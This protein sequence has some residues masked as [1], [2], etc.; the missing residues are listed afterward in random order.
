[1][2]KIVTPVSRKPERGL[3][4]QRRAGRARWRELRDGGRELGRIGD[5]GHAPDDTDD[6][7]DERRGAERQPDGIALVPEMAM[8]TI[9]TAVRPSRS[10]TRPATMHPAPPTPT[11]RNAARLALVGLS[12]PAAR[13]LAARNSGTQVHMAYSSHMWPR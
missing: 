10:A 11:I 1:M 3:D 8:A 4:R 9:V 13:K 6:D 2:A 7:R 5:D 12:V